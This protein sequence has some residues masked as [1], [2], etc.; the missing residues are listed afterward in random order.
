MPAVRRLAPPPPLLDPARRL[1]IEQANGESR[2]DSPRQTV[3]PVYPV[4][5]RLKSAKNDDA[6]LL[7]LIDMPQG[8]KSA[9]SPRDYHSLTAVLCPRIGNAPILRRTS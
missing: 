5:T 2:Y 8:R 9:R 4:A 1:D 3:I 7:D 6:V